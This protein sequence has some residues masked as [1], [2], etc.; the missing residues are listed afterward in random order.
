MLG[1]NKLWSK[2][3]DFTVFFYL[4]IQLRT[5]SDC[6]HC[7]RSSHA[8]PCQPRRHTHVRVCVTSLMVHLAALFASTHS[9]Y[10]NVLRNMLVYMQS[11]YTVTTDT[12]EIHFDSLTPPLT[13]GRSWSHLGQ[14]RANRLLT[15]PRLMVVVG[16]IFRS[17]ICLSFNDRDQSL[18]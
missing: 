1:V 18:T 8:I 15:R 3:P 2:L 17:Q 13:S 10:Q 4:V 5:Y 12:C 16:F 11:A 14:L 7:D 9:G 6:G